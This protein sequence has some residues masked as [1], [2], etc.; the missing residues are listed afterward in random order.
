[1]RRCV[2]CAL[3]I[4]LL[5]AWSAH[6]Q[7]AE[8]Q[9]PPEQPPAQP[10]A[11]GELPLAQVTVRP[12]ER[13]DGVDRPFRYIVAL[14]PVGIA[15]VEVIGDRRLVSFELRATAQTGRRARVLRCRHPSAPR[16]VARAR[17]TTI[18]ARGPDTFWREWIDLRMYCSGRALAALSQGAEVRVR[19]GYSGRPTQTRWVARIETLPRAEWDASLDAPP[20]ALAA[21]AAEPTRRIVAP[22]PRTGPTPNRMPTPPA[23]AP[24]P[25]RL[26]LSPSSARSQGSLLFRVA[27]RTRQGRRRIYVRPDR[28]T[29]RVRGPDGETSCEVTPGGGNPAPELFSSISS[30]RPA[31]STLDADFFCPRGTFAREGVYEVTPEVDLPFAG[32][33]YHYNAV[34]GRY[35]GPTVPIRITHGA[36]GYVAQELRRTVRQRE[37]L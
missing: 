34:T 36:G 16:R 31:R 30:R 6:A 2:F 32:E 10:Q 17:M 7:Q 26:D 19:Y 8:E 20:F 5:V 23:P 28:F 35:A 22:E 13:F 27:I 18:S 14:H 12:W 25:I 9:A 21:I 11:E 1:M 33:D 29:F 15:P 37:S 3:L 4:A 24:V